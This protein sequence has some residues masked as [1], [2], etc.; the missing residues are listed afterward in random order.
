[1]QPKGLCSLAMVG[2][3]CWLLGA[4]NAV[5][6]DLGSSLAD[7]VSEGK[8]TC[9]GLYSVSRQCLPFSGSHILFHK[10]LIPSST[11]PIAS[12]A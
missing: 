11:I 8:N 3:L 10:N 6:P 12:A 4:P 1:M 9:W 7:D 5:W 2:D